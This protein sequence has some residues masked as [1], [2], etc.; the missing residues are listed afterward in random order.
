MYVRNITSELLPAFRPYLIPEAV[1]AMEEN[2]S[3]VFALG[4]VTEDHRTCG[5][6]AALLDEAGFTLFSL[7]VDPAIRRQGTATLLLRELEK[8]AGTALTDAEWT[9]PDAEF[10]S[11]DAFLCRQGFAPARREQGGVM[12]LDAD[13]MRTLPMVRRAISPA[14]RPDANILPFSSISSEES[15]DLL[16]DGSIPACLR[17]DSFTRE[18][19]SSPMSLAYRYGGRIAAYLLA[20]PAPD[21]VAVL[22]A[23]SRDGCHSGAFLQL[24]MAALHYSVPFLPE[25]HG[26]YWLE[27]LNDTAET[28]ARH[29][30]GGSPEIWYAGHA[31]R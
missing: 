7:H 17:P 22:A 23:V 3:G 12:R 29:F 27:A 20:E 19:L 31:Q 4:A 2:I 26:S 11:V 25:G 28:L 9:L 8:F 21:G 24:A 10:L 13:T 15:A 14:F 6:A 18:Q 5:A 1:R 16:S 30:S